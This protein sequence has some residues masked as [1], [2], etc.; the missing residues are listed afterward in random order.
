[1]IPCVLQGAILSKFLLQPEDNRNIFFRALCVLDVGLADQPT[2]Y[3]CTYASR[4]HT[5][6]NCYMLV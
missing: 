6:F 3:V 1:M 4:T 5:T 2:Y